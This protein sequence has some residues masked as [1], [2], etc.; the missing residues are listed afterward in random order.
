MSQNAPRL[1]LVLADAELLL[2]PERLRRHPAIVRHA[3]RRGKRPGEMLLDSSYHHAASK[4]GRPDIVHVCL[5]NAM[6]SIL[7]R[8]GLLRVYVHTIE[9][10]V[11]EVD[12]STRVPRN[13]NRFVGL[14]E[15][16]LVK[17]CVPEGLCL[18]KVRRESLGELIERI[19]AGEGEV[20]VMHE[21]GEPVQ[22]RTLGRILTGLSR[23][24]V[25]IGAF[26]HGDFRS[27]V[28]WRKI[29]LYREPLMAWTVVNEVITNFEAATPMGKAF[30]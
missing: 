21:G 12:P 2:V 5:L 3:R 13:Y 27:S 14:M 26:P 19:G 4:I 17:G 30:L 9:D 15:S 22:P 16:L 11:I 20:F 10:R 6:D 7:N 25:I 24:T 18:L 1:N 29:S 8:M 28:P 23:P